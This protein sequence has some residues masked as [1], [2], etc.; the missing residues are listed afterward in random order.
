KFI[1]F[2]KSINAERIIKIKLFTNKLE[3][4][5]C[6]PKL[7]GRKIN[8]DPGYVTDAKLV[9]ATTKD[10]CH[11]IYL[12]GGIFGEVT[13]GFKEGSFRDFPWTYPDYRKLG[14]I[15]FFNEVR[16]IYLKQIKQYKK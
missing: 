11:R 5:T 3:G 16:T 9:L 15:N 12:G 10:Y 4:I 13:L 2:K 6:R 1:S 8:L 14:Y 7:S